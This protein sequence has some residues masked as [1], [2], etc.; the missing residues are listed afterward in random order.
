MSNLRLTCPAC[1]QQ[2][3]IRRPSGKRATVRCRSCGKAFTFDVPPA[4]EPDP[5][6]LFTDFA[7]GGLPPVQPP[8]AAA[9]LRPATRRTPATQSPATQSPATQS[10]ATQRPSAPHHGIGSRRPAA[11]QRNWLAP[12][13][14]VSSLMVA[15]AVI[16]VG[17]WMLLSNTS[18][19]PAT[20]SIFDSA[21]AIV[22]QADE[23]DTELKRWV[24]ENGPA[25]PTK[26]SQSKLERLSVDSMRLVARAVLLAPLDENEAR[27][28]SDRHVHA[29][30]D[31]LAGDEAA[32]DGAPQGPLSDDQISA[33]RDKLNE[34]PE[35]DRM[36]TRALV[37]AA[38]KSSAFTREYLRFGHR[39]LPPS[40]TQGEQIK[41]KQIEL[42][43]QLNRLAAKVV[44]RIDP[45]YSNRP[46][47]EEEVTEFLDKI[48]GPIVDDVSL[49]ADKMHRLAAA[50][51]EV[52]KE[53][54]GDPDQFDEIMYYTELAQGSLLVANMAL[55]QSKAKITKPLSDFMI[56]SKD[57]DRAA[58][59]L[60]PS[61]MAEQ[62]AA[63]QQIESERIRREQERKDRIANQNRQQEEELRQEK[64]K[65]DAERS[66]S[67]RNQDS[68]A[69][70]D[71]SS[72][73]QP[74][75]RA[76]SPG[77]GPGFGPRF[78]P[79][80][81]SGDPNSGDPFGPPGSRAGSRF[82]PPA[83]FGNR[84]FGARGMGDGGNRG[85]AAGRAGRP[86]PPVIEPGTGV[87]I[88]MDD[89]SSVNTSELSKTF[90]NALRGEHTFASQ[91][92]QANT[93]YRLQRPTG[94]SR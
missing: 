62:E 88:T 38:L 52:P 82:G 75:D 21:S 7:G 41:V 30:D 16:G 90:S 69:A 1:S 24:D 81:N 19:L 83:G 56:A 50:R 78:G 4:K 57:V 2:I 6:P 9:P 73:V 39:E 91:Q 54:V 47:T 53:Q 93:A 34:L 80:R 65:A 45:D 32:E 92:R 37:G 59:G 64:L 74:A 13:L 44:M 87:T 26:E 23:N 8:N 22:A 25:A 51:Y 77:F 15:T 72:N 66:L 48:Y 31:E 86:A 40:G 12:F 46:E 42:L 36:M 58:M 71:L 60:K 20:I 29:A 67:A 27:K 35:S 85:G 49:L 18:V 3:T 5:D 79:G 70:P 28:I 17:T 14:I 55:V 63:Q 10:R 68:P 89:A 61:R 94:S 76:R 33:M 11:P 84:G 43:R